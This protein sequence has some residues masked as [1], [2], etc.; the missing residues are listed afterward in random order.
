[1]V[2]NKA[3]ADV[4][5]FNNTDVVRTSNYKGVEYSSES[6]FLDLITQMIG[7]SGSEINDALRHI[8]HCN[9]AANAW[10]DLLAGE[11]VGEVQNT[12]EYWHS[13]CARYTILSGAANYSSEAESDIF[14]KEWD[15][16][17]TDW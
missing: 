5:V 7:W 16:S 1:M 13:L 10:A 6:N 9:N 11:S 2:Y 4:I 12:A 15:D 14:D 3:V 17:E 8:T